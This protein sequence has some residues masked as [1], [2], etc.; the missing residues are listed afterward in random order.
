VHCAHRLLSEAT[1]ILRTLL[2]GI[3]KAISASSSRRQSSKHGGSGAY[4]CSN[5][6]LHQ[7]FLFGKLNIIVPSYSAFRKR[8]NRPALCQLCCCYVESK[9][10]RIPSVK[11]WEIIADNLK[12]R[13]W[14]LGYVS[15]VD[16]EGR[17]IW[18]ADAHRDDGKRFVAVASANRSTACCSDGRAAPF[19][20][21][22]SVD[23][24]RSCAPTTQHA[25]QASGARIVTK[26][27]RRRPPDAQL[28]APALHLPTPRATGRVE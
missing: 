17:T 6:V 14:S 9:N 5:N 13:D 12:K 24:T 19:T 21:F 15:A 26:R 2:E 4:Q 20:S 22:G 23:R 1:L 8:D 16:S 28:S 25:G 7:V 10:G 18:I 3:T 27:R 11:Y